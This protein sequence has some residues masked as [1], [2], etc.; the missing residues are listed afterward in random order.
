M[1]L[2][3]SPSGSPAS[4]ILR[5]E[6]VDPT[7]VVRDL[8]YQTSPNLFVSRGT[9]GLGVPPVTLN[10]EKLPT[11]PGG[12]A[13]YTATGPREIDLPIHVSAASLGALELAVEYLRAWFDT[14]DESG[15]RFG[16]LRIT[17]PSDDGVRQVACLYAGGLE[18]DLEDGGPTSCTKVV[19]LLAPDPAWTPTA[20][21]EATYDQ[22]DIGVTQAIIN[23]GDFAAYPV[24][25]ITGPASA[26]TLTNATTGKTLALT[27]NGGLALGTAE[28][29]TIDTRPPYQRSTLAVIDDDGTA[30]SNK[31]APGGSLWHFAP[32]Q[33]NFTIAATGAT[34]DT[35]I[36]LA[37]LPRYRG[38]LR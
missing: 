25:T 28:T 11:M 23:L 20:D 22:S 4:G 17:R 7:G 26:I 31:I 3:L 8:T 32:G 16:Y 36:A 13:R 37:W 1:P 38:V 19:S 27:A 10:V 18:G 35:A 5:W 33:N 30:H 21:E 34:V 29:L 9:A 14:G 12:V 24:W 15:R 2:V 6:W